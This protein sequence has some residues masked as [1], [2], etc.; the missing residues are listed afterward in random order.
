MASIICPPLAGT[1]MFPFSS[2]QEK[3][4][5]MVAAEGRLDRFD[6]E[7]N[8]EYF[9]D[10]RKFMA[11]TFAAWDLQP[12]SEDYLQFESQNLKKD[13][14]RKF[15]FS[16]HRLG[17]TTWSQK[18]AA[19]KVQRGEVRKQNTPANETPS[20]K[21]VGSLVASTAKRQPRIDPRRSEEELR[22]ARVSTIYILFKLSNNF[23][24]DN[25]S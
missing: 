3:V 1:R 21:Q 4:H 25:F 9:E 20:S 13:F 11:K 7:E 23:Q 17:Q 5:F 24:V 15:P 19:I 2:H 10:I 8:L 22:V 18:L 16:S 14:P 12:L 6:G